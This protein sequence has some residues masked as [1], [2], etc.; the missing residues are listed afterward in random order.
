M[1]FGPIVGFREFIELALVRNDVF[2]P[3]PLD[4]LYP[5]VRQVVAFIMVE[6]VAPKADMRQIK[7]AGA[8]D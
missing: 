4:D 3:K 6:P 5:L 8:R 1:A 7:I 2:C